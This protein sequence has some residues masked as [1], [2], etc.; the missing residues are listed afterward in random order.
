MRRL[1][2]RLAGLLRRLLHALD[3]RLV[4]DLA[5]PRDGLSAEDLAAG[6]IG[7]ARE[8][9]VVG[10]HLAHLR[11]QDTRQ[12]AVGGV[13]RLHRVGAPRLHVL[14]RAARLL[15]RLGDLL[16]SAV[17]QP[18]DRRVALGLGGAHLLGDAALAI[19]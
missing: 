15:A 1:H 11:A 2:D 12:I 16:L 3:H 14:D 17:L 13:D 7:D 19:L 8:G 4:G 18:L 5:L 10:E 6:L 9:D